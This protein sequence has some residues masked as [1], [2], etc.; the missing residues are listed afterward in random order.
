[1]HGLAASKLAGSC[2]ISVTLR[3]PVPA[4]LYAMDSVP[5]ILPSASVT[6]PSAATFG[7]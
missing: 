7:P 2:T 3:A 5:A 1:M 6:L 4:S